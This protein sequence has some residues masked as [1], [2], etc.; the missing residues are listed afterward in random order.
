MI[1]AWL[2]WIGTAKR[3][4]TDNVDYDDYAPR[5]GD[6]TRPN[7]G[8]PVHRPILTW[9]AREA[10]ELSVLTARLRMQGRRSV[11][12]DSH[13]CAASARSPCDQFRVPAAPICGGGEVSHSFGVL[14]KRHWSHAAENLLTCD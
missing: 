4:D 1:Q 13:G 6:L 9:Q 11:A 7:L 2:N 5:R 12:A 10:G 3:M 8:A 14:A